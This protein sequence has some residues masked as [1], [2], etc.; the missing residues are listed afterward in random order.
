MSPPPAPCGKRFGSTAVAGIKHDREDKG[1][2]GLAEQVTVG[3]E[4]WRTTSICP[5]DGNLS[6]KQL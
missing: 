1:D 6:N 5:R 3:R 2:P 4:G